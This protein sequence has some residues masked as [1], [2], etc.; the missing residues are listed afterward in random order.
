MPSH[1]RLTWAVAVA[2]LA[3]L[4][5]APAARASSVVVASKV[6]GYSAGGRAITAYE[7]GDPRA[8]YKAVVLGSMHG[9]WE[10]AGEQV[11]RAIR[12]GGI[13][14]PAGLDLWVI[15]TLNPDGDAQRQRGNAHGV[16]LNRNWP[17]L[18]TYIA[19]T[20]S[21][22]DSHYSGPSPLSEPETQAMHSF[23]LQV[24]PN[25]LVSLHQPLDGV[26]STD[27]GATDIAFRSALS[28]ELGL[29]VKALTCNGGCH[30]SMAG[31]LTNY[32][33]TKA[34]TVEFP[35]PQSAAASPTS[36]SPST[37]YLAGPAARGV[38]TAIMVG[39]TAST[40][41]AYP[42]LS[43]AT[44]NAF[45]TKL[46]QRILGR[47]PDPG[48][49]RAYAG[50]LQAGATSQ[51]LVATTI[52]TSTEHLHA[53]VAVA[54]QQCL[55]RGADPGGLNA[56]TAV[57][58]AGASWSSVLSALC[59][60]GEA[61]A[62]GGST[63]GG[64]VM[65]VFAG[66]LGRSP[67]DAHEREVWANVAAHSGRAGTITQLVGTTESTTRALNSVYLALLRRGVDSSGVASFSSAMPGRGVVTVPISLS[68]SAEFARS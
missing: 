57:L 45:V 28:A 20:S 13:G 61:Y 17:N 15:D 56:F 58:H 1:S 55:G 41:P 62:R 8:L 11:V 63:L 64:W 65:K 7:L 35:G 2:I 21:L 51:A 23:L 50:L 46:Y 67:T 49:L 26:D 25:R 52:S 16:D 48:G 24:R 27:G 36:G 60:S 6:I 4:V 68:L 43:A 29:P 10:M 3:G 22:F 44:A 54:Y 42:R 37:A 38:L 9:Y 30:G 34:I 59:G 31:W 40:P 5:V 14:I 12:G 19:P 53:L 66:L 33:S 32:T 18:W 47:N 39:V